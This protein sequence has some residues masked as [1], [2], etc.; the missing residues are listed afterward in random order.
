[1]SARIA[2]LGLGEAGSTF[3]RSL[4]VHTAVTGW[5]PFAAAEVEGVRLAASGEEAVADADAVL[6]FTTA[7]H[8]ADAL[9]T[10]IAAAPRA[11]VH[12][13]FAT[14][15]PVAK[16]ELADRAAAAGIRFA[17]AAIMAP[18]RKGADRTP[19]LL[20]GDAEATA[21]LR[22]ILRDAGYLV[23]V[24]DGPA[25]TSA[26]RK[27]LRSMLVK[28]LTGVMVESLRA[29]EAQGL[30]D[31]FAEHLVETLAGLDRP[32]LA[33]LLDGTRQHSGRR[34]EEMEA[35]AEMAEATGGRADIARAVAEVL[36]SVATDGVPD[37]GRL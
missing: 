3:A 30:S 36:R 28:G 12:A 15:A 32:T 33:G 6:A 8:S 2:V 20:S 13:D 4:A 34:I 17:D 35:A 29:A 11:A 27:L 1:M 19:V 26:A 5:D 24:L 18:V 7:A 14:A 37:G 16:V 9:T 25:G 23:E 21:D 31:W 22:A 10:T